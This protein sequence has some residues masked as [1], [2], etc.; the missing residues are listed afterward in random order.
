[1]LVSSLGSKIE[2]I[3]DVVEG[4][5]S[6]NTRVEPPQSGPSQQEKG[7]VVSRS[8]TFAKEVDEKESEDD[9]DENPE[10]DLGINSGDGY[11]SQGMYRDIIVEGFDKRFPSRLA[12][13]KPA[14]FPIDDPITRTLAASKYSAKTQ[15]HSITIANAFFPR[16]PVQH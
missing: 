8:V 14:Y 12:S 15:E 3:A 2:T 4:S 13:N 16:L 11:V 1:M 10:D 9:E 7:K 6:N 5:S